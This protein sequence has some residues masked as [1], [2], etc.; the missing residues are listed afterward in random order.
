MACPARVPDQAPFHPLL[1]SASQSDRAVMGPHA[2]ETSRVTNA[3]Q[4]APNSP[5]RRLV[6]R[7]KQFPEIGPDYRKVTIPSLGSFGPGIKKVATSHQ[8]DGNVMARA[9]GN[10]R[11]LFNQV[12]VPFNGKRH[13]V[14]YGAPFGTET[15]ASFDAVRNGALWSARRVPPRAMSAKNMATTVKTIIPS[16]RGRG[17]KSAHLFVQKF[18]VVLVHF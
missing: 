10:A 3:M 15:V 6:S 8:R 12:I 13:R 9:I 1:L 17:L 11:A 16:F 14:P 5:M 4:P 2:Q 18:P 7:A